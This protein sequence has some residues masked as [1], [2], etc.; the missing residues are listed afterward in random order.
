MAT[1]SINFGG[2]ASGLDTSS[3]IDSLVAAESQPLTALKA[4]ASDIAAASSTVSAF[5]STLSSLASAATALS[6]P[7]GFNA[8]TATTSSPAVVATT[9]GS[10]TAGSYDIQVSQLARAQRTYSDSQTSSTADLGMTGNLSLTVGS[11]AA[12]NIPVTSDMSLTD[13]AAAISASGARVSA[14]V[15]Y[16][17]S[18]YRLQ[19]AGLDSGAANAVSFG[20]SG[21][22]LG[23]SNAANTYQQAQDAKFTVDGIAMTRSTNQVVGAVAG[24]TLALTATTSSPA[25]LNVAPDATGLT[26]KLQTFVSAYNAAVSAVHSAVGYGGTA[27]TNTALS[28]NSAMRSALDQLTAMLGNTVAGATGRYTTMASVGV[29][30]QKDGTLAL[31][32]GALSA[33]IAADPTSVS[34]LFVT[35]TSTSSTGVMKAIASRIS[36][37]TA[38]QASLLTAQI[39]AF[40]QQ[41]K[42][43]TDQEAKMQ[44]RV[45]A[46]KT[47]LQKSFAQMEL[48]VQ[49]YKT[50]ASSLDSLNGIS[51]SSSSSGSS[52]SS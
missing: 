26:S 51:S 18:S 44:A 48:I 43:M 46:Y 29:N 35:D 9:T 42:S 11:G 8:F 10:A 7:S 6:T 34:R 14:S 45:D 21:F 23:L 31:D 30:L 20:E 22:S 1:S 40:G 27:A 38:N 41:T 25:S 13:V 2:L 24:V 36:S 50:A 49:K 17:G 33:A 37:Y 12:V 28:N 47:N 4:K 5:T 19:V 39:N 3:I 32:T 15:V 52:S 16:D